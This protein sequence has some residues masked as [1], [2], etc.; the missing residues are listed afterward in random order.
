MTKLLWLTQRGERHQQSALEAAPPQIE[1]FIRRDPH[2][3]EL[4]RLLAEVDFLISERSGIVSAAMVATAP[5]LK[6]I[7]RLGALDDDIDLEA[8]R[9]RGI[10]VS[11]QPV[12][13]SIR[14]AEHLIMALT[15]PNLP[16]SVP[17]MDNSLSVPMKIPSVITGI[18]LAG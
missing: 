5:K 14:V 8:C 18:D 13:G 2:P 15:K 9:A 6:L 11:R 16:P 12:I 17:S 7:V 10:V 4:N 1:V 3:D